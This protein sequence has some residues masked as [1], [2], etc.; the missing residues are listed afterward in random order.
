M[1]DLDALLTEA[2]ED[3]LYNRGLIISAVDDGEPVTR[4]EC[5]V[6]DLDMALAAALRSVPVPVTEAMVDVV[7][8]AVY[9][10]NRWGD[11]AVIRDALTAALALLSFG[12]TTEEG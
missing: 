5:D 6:R 7:Q 11:R 1:P 2:L 8:E 9:D 4:V 10:D 3:E 12:T